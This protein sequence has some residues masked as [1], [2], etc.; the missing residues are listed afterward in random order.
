MGVCWQVILSTSV[1]M[2][3][4]SFGWSVPGWYLDGL[5]LWSFLQPGIAL[6]KT[7]ETQ[8]S[9]ELVMAGS[10]N[11]KT[12]I[13]IKELFLKHQS[14]E[15]GEGALLLRAPDVLLEDP[16]YIPGTY[17]QVL[18]LTAACNTSF[19]DLMP[20]YGVCRHPSGEKKAQNT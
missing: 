15:T 4:I 20:S 6:E 17:V 19:R 9:I 10:Y 12:K 5:S 13:F 8:A 16:S 2:L 14:T 3:G 11:Y 7:T 1:G 18:W